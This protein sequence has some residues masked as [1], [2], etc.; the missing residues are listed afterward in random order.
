MAEVYFYMKKIKMVSLSGLKL[1]SMIALDI[2][3]YYPD[4]D[5]VYKVNL[6]NDYD[7]SLPKHR[8]T[9]DVHPYLQVEPTKVDFRKPVRADLII[10]IE[11]R[12]TY[13]VDELDLE[14]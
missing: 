3:P 11:E 5:W 2:A 14:G 10:N 9:S 12:R 13:S 1:K 4:A 8:K 7:F 6:V